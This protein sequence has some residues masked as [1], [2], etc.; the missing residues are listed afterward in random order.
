MALAREVKLNDYKLKW[1]F[2]HLSS[3]RVFCYVHHFRMQEA[4]NQST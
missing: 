2:R 3:T 1:R 4:I